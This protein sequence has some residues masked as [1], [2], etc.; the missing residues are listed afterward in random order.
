MDDG[1]NLAVLRA[2]RNL[3][4]MGSVAAA[5][6]AVVLFS[7][8]AKPARA[9]LD[10]RGSE[11]RGLQGHRSERRGAE[12][13]GPERR[14][15]DREQ[16]NGDVRCFLKGTLIR[17][18]EGYRKIEDLK[19]GDLLPTVFGGVRPIEWI[20]RYPYKKSDPSK[21]W[22]KDVRPVRIARSALGPNVPQA[23]LYVTQAHEVL[24]DGVLVPAANLINGTTIALDEARDRDELEYFHIKLERHDVIDAEGA[25]C[26]TLYGVDES[27]VNFADHLR[28][29][30]PAPVNEVR[31]A[32]SLGPIS[33]GGRPELKS[34]LRSALSPWIDRRHELDVLRDRLEE[35]GIP[36]SCE[37]TIQSFCANG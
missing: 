12:E 29:Y 16:R 15:S 17:T 20:G 4:K 14:W 34:R 23:D 11:W 2:R 18:A 10:W 5:S 25:P 33:S 35:H 21:A 9:A 19:I 1:E 3:I 31:C 8:K 37:A 13:R 36:D 27:A 26:E 28:H 6:A 7:L 22:V 24:I 32:P 30:G